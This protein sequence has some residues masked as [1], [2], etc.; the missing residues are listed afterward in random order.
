MTITAEH[1]LAACV[2]LVVGGL[3]GALVPRMIAWVPEPEASPDEAEPA[4]PKR[5]YREV[6]DGPGLTWKAAVAT[7]L[8]GAVVGLTLGWDWRLLPLLALVPLGVALAVIDW[9]TTLL[10]TRLIVPAYVV[11]GVLVLVAALLMQDE[12]V[13]IRAVIGWVATFLVFFLLWFIWP[14]GMGYGDV[15]LSG[16][17]GMALGA[18]GYAELVTGVYGAFILG[19]FGGLLL[20]ALKI[21]DRKRY[22]FGPFM[23]VGALVGVVAG[24]AIASGLG[25]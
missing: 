7:A 22:P 23:L 11:V 13:A 10:P 14:S 21:V 15:R 24:P 2:A 6:A 8:T 5:L 19:G 17:L 12:H 9:Q 20:S 4:E 16:V 18:V 1:W 3:L 25:W